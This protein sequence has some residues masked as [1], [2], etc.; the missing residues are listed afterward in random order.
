M[1][2]TEEFSKFSKATLVVKANI[3]ALRKKAG[4]KMN[5]GAALLGVSRKQLEDIETTRNYG[6]HIDLE[7]LAKVCALYHTTADEV[8]GDTPKTPYAMYYKR[9]RV[10]LG[11][12][13]R[14]E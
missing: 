12:A 13:G 11:S 3:K 5:D 9:P 7:L 14:G 8:I 1:R 10:R 2:K 6:C 4:F